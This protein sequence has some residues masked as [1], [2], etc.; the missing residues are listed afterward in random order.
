[1]TANATTKK[2]IQDHYKIDVD[3]IRN[4]SKLANDLTKNGKLCV[5]GGLEVDGKLTVKDSLDVNDKLIV[6]GNLHAIKEGDG[7]L[8]NLK[9]NTENK[10]RDGTDYKTKSGIEVTF[11]NNNTGTSFIHDTRGIT[12]L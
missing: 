10:D 5:P 12:D 7:Y 4:L 2:L 1:M 11:K 3:A 6:K 8:A 9:K